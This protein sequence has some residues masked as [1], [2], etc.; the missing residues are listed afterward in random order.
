M[1]KKIEL[2]DAQNKAIES[3]TIRLQVATGAFTHAV[4]AAALT[5]KDVVA[6]QT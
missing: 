2:N 6:E 5:F 1:A 3:A 4:A